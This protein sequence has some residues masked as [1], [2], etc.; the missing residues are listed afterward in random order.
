MRSYLYAPVLRVLTLLAAGSLTGGCGVFDFDVDQ[1]VPEQRIMGSAIAALLPTFIP[2][3]F[4]LTIN[5]SEETQ[6]HGTGPAQSAGLTSLTFQI[7]DT[8]MPPGNFGFV[9]SISIYISSTMQGTMLTQQ[10][11]ADL[12]NP[13]GPVPMMTLQT[14]PNVNLLPYINEGSDIT[15]MAT[16]NAPSQDTT[17]DG[18]IVVHVHTF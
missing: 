6:A 4:P 15:S 14:Y 8:A 10:L 2:N 5:L 16:G 1:A 13:P 7:T 3:P 18:Q 11:I 12:P 17:F 9:Q